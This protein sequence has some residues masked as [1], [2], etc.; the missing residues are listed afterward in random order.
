[1]VG[2]FSDHDLYQRNR[3]LVSLARQL[4]P[5]SVVVRPRGQREPV[6]PLAPGGRGLLAKLA[7]LS[8]DALGIV[9]RRRRLAGSDLVFVPYPAYV[10]LIVLWLIGA[11]RGRTVVAD[12]FLDLE[13]TVRDRGLLA[14]GSWRLPVLRW[15]ERFALSRA[16]CV[17]IDTPEQSAALGRRLAGSGTRVAVVPVGIDEA[18]W[19]PMP[20][21]DTAGPIRVLFWGTFIPLHGV[22]T[23]VAAAQRVADC[24]ADF[25]FRLIGDGQTAPALAERLRARPVPGL[26]WRREL[27]DTATLREELARS[28]IL[29]GI[30]GG[31]DK[32]AAVIPY[33]VQQALACNRPLI[34][35]ASP[36]MQ[37][38]ADPQAGLVTVPAADAEALA[39]ALIALA[40]R[41]RN[42]WVAH[43]RPIFD[44]HFSSAVL[45]ERLRVAF[46]GESPGP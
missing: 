23:I 31:S 29:L 18:L 12:A 38:H 20:A 26:S 41:L 44:A 21:P 40:G 24:H 39:A 2:A 15:L 4:F 33:K 42:G 13:S 35:R 1:M 10:D 34:T 27:V 22:E 6:N 17:L 37:A 46:D 32:A 25:E 14:E 30:F 43:T 3:V 36:A 5:R 9:G 45:R 8:A 19:S 16:D 11:T 28:H 7:Q